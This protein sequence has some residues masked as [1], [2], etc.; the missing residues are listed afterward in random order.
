MPLAGIRRPTASIAAVI[1]F[2]SLLALAP[3]SRA[4]T[5]IAAPVARSEASASVDLAK[6]F[7][8]V[9]D[10]IDRRFVNEQILKELDWQ[11]RAKAVRAS[12]LAAA[13]TAEAVDRINQLL[14]ELKTSHTDLATPDDYRY[15][16]TPMRCSV[17]QKRRT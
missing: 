5:S 13:T 7:D 9:V 3:S 6:L 4:E 12:V 17:Q 8:A 14:A 11:A 16:F 15:Y 2:I 10:T 1:A